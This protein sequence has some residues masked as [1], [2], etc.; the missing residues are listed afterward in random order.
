[1]SN[2]NK[3]NNKKNNNWYKKLISSAIKLKDVQR[4]FAMNMMSKATLTR[5]IIVDD[6]DFKLISL[7]E[8]TKTMFTNKD[9]INEYG[10]RNEK[11]L[12]MRMPHLLNKSQ[13]AILRD[14][15]DKSNSTEPD[16]V[17]NL[18]EYQCPISRQQLETLIGLETVRS[19]WEIPE[20]AK[21]RNVCIRGK[22]DDYLKE[23]WVFIRKYSVDS[24]PWIA[25]HFDSNI[26]TV[27]IALN[28]DNQ[29][30]GG[31]L[32]AIYDGGI[33]V[34]KRKEGDA[35]VHGNTMMHGVTR[36]NKG[37]R[38]SLILFFG[39]DGEY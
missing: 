10:Y 25:L 28:G 4:N 12:I 23:V 36:M 3:D 9:L 2:T 11:E 33:Q 7:E 21:K 37:T 24:R 18:P 20:L 19:I 13:C 26:Y 16:S 27:N 5:S 38:Y 14:V 6:L 29:Y 30:E 15:V 17:D 22:S 39:G 1:M 31:R 8:V 32:L 35:M 34:I